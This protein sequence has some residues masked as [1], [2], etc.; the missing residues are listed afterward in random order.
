[1]TKRRYDPSACKEDILNAAE[2]LF[3]THGFGDVSTK[4]IAKEAGVS[5]SQIHYHFQTK[6][7][8]WSAI[9]QRRFAEY[10]TIQSKMLQSDERQGMERMEASIRAYFDFFRRNPKFIKLIIRAQLG[11]H[12]E[13]DETMSSTL[14]EE[15]VAS[16]KKGQHDGLIRNDV[17]PEHVLIGFTSLVEYWFQV[18]EF[19]LLGK[20]D[21]D[22]EQHDDQYLNFIL[23][24]FLKGL[25]P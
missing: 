3:A 24:V 20:E 1:M 7:N 10:F 25:T 8:L 15:G 17:E 2:H 19:Y 18:R 4:T 6:R 21:D 23:K 22:P 11:G 12:T 14:L 16:I 9:F 13:D 5:Q